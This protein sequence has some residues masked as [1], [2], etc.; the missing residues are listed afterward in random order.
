MNTIKT[1]HLILEPKEGI[2]VTDGEF[3]PLQ[4]IEVKVSNKKIVIF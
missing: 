2:L 3:L 1:N 4:N